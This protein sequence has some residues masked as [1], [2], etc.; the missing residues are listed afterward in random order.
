M[1]VALV[2]Q[3][4][5]ALI[6]A[7]LAAGLVVVDRPAA[8][9]LIISYGG[10]GTLLGAE[11]DFPG[12]PKLA[13]RDARLCRKCEIHQTERI[14]ADL[15]AHRIAS[16]ELP[17]LAALTQGSSLVGLNDIILRNAVITS[18]VRYRVW[19]ND[20]PY[21]GEIVGDGLVVATPFGS[22]AYYRSIT[23]SLIRTGIGLAFN[24]STEPIS[25]LVLRSSDR[26]RLRITRGP[27]VLAADNNPAHISL[28]PR[29]T[30]EICQSEQKA[31]ILGIDGLRCSACLRQQAAAESDERFAF[32]GVNLPPLL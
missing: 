20:H 14:L 15:A 7:L 16:V 32:R 12:I 25:H 17:K 1:R 2:G 9:D 24:N 3:D 22:S 26:I 8:S 13:I 21:S 19:I 29:D 30:V 18:G 6:P 23:H 11:R 31:I 5:A 27:A 10:D 28:A 4:G